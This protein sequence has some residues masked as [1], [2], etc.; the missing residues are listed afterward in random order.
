M[1][2]ANTKKTIVLVDDEPLLINALQRLL[3]NNFHLLIVTKTADTAPDYVQTTLDILN[4]NDVD[5]V[6]A[7]LELGSQLGYQIIEKV[8]ATRKIP[9]IIQSGSYLALNFNTDRTAPY[10]YLKSRIHAFLQKPVNKEVLMQAIKEALA[11][12]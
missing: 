4:E 6:I 9:F 11:T 1:D 12:G 2:A 7:D 10:K 3:K 5:L 8:D